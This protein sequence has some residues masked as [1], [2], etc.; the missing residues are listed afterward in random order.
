M[1]ESQQ[2]PFTL[3]SAR[4]DS[5]INHLVLNGQQLVTLTEYLL[6][7]IAMLFCEEFNFLSLHFVN[8]I[9]AMVSFLYITTSQ[10]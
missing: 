2:N 9:A 4:E 3:S 6:N 7:L 1:I 8:E 5:M 10:K